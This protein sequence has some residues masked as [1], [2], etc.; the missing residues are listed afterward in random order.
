MPFVKGSSGNPKGRAKGSTNRTTASLKDAIL[1]AAE[2]VGEDG[3]GKGGLRGYLVGLA[4]SE[5]K[6]FS[7]LLG[8]VVPLQVVGEGDGPLTVVV[9]KLTDG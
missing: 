2:D 9:R 8:R 4:K 3:R 1:L 5:P 6:A 7:S